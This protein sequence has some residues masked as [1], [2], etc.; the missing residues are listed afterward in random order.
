MKISFVVVSIKNSFV[1]KF[2]VI[3]VS[4][5]FVIFVIFCQFLSFRWFHRECHQ[6][7]FRNQSFH[8]FISS[9]NHFFISLIISSFFISLILY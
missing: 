6:E 3:F 2:V 5:Y 4:F 1:I 8:F 7:I 9:I